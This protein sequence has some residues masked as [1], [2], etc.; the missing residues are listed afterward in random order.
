[1]NKIK[2]YA[3]NKKIY[4]MNTLIVSCHDEKKSMD[5]LFIFV[6][7]LWI[8][9]GCSSE[10]SYEHH[11]NFDLLEGLNISSMKDSSMMRPISFGKDTQ[12]FIS[13][14]EWI[15]NNRNGWEVYFHTTPAGKHYISGDGLSLIIGD[16]WVILRDKDSKDGNQRQLSRK[17][18]IGSFDFLDS[19]THN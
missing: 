3:N 2:T 14:M 1:M 18:P 9:V 10:H 17:I 7:V 4:K 13:T 6:L 19:I 8:L 12:V 5:R 16:D 15:E 11:L